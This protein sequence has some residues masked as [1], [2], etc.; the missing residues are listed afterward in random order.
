[1]K[2]KGN[3]I[4]LVVIIILGIAAIISTT[5]TIM[6]FMQKSDNSESIEYAEEVP[7]DTSSEE[8][9]EADDSVTDDINFTI[10][11]VKDTP[12]FDTFDYAQADDPITC[13]E[14]IT[15]PVFNNYIANNNLPFE[16]EPYAISRYFYEN[17]MVE[18]TVGFR[19]TDARL[20]ATRF[21][22]GE[23]D[24]E[25]LDITNIY[26]SDYSIIIFDNGVP[27]N[28]QDIYNAMYDQDIDI[29]IYRSDYVAGNTVNLFT[30]TGETITFNLE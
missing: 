29:D 20:I 7:I 15:T 3:K 4:L 28:S 8:I 5:V 12:K 13:E 22:E 6:L 23:T 1:M 9:A 19:N 24:F 21:P 10:T 14:F 25:F 16:L 30:G 27:E 2:N 18:Y 11:D 17:G 26:G